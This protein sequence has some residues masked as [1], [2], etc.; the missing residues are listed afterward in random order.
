MKK[1]LC[2][3]L[4][5][6]LIIG[7]SACGKPEEEPVESV[8]Q[9]PAN[10][11][12]FELKQ[13]AVKEAGSYSE[14]GIT[15]SV[16]E[17]AYEPDATKLHLK[18]ENKSNQSV[19]I[20]TA[21]LSVNGMMSTNSLMWGVK[22]MTTE[23]GFISIGNDWFQEMGIEQIIDIQFVIKVFN[24]Q[25]VEMMQ[26]DVITVKT[27]VS[28]EYQQAYDNSGAEI[29][30]DNGIKLCVRTLQKSALSDDTEIVLY[31]ENF[32]DKTVTITSFD[33]R[34]NKTEIKP[35]FVMSVGAGK[36]AVDTMVLKADDLLKAEIKS[37]NSVV[38]RFKAFDENRELLFETIELKL[39]FEKVEKE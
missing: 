36:L 1:I 15:V 13:N 16:L 35:D 12:R 39:P 31:A 8:I 34:V 4:A 22:P 28:E 30:N 20:M 3:L 6:N 24:A 38:A 11:S 14:N 10:P 32:T 9:L 37:V 27:D 2:L 33:V 7:L 17:L 5:L 26:S 29:Y 21:H 19:R 18:M 25:D 23:N